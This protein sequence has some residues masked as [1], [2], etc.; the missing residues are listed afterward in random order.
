MLKIGKYIPLFLKDK[1]P[2]K[3]MGPHD[4]EPYSFEDLFT[5]H[6]WNRKHLVDF[7][8]FIRYDK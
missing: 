4:V 5:K 1:P 7:W 3:A 8:I 6:R 2:F